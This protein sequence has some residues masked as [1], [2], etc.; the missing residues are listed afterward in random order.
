MLIAAFIRHVVIPL[1][2]YS[3][4]TL[5]ASDYQCALFCSQTLGL[6][7]LESEYCRTAENST[8]KEH[9]NILCKYHECL[10]CSFSSLI[11]F[12]L[13]SIDSTAALDRHLVRKGRERKAN[14]RLSVYFKPDI[15]PASTT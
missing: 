3:T 11:A 9:V 5:L 13:C 2:I 8:A 4:H 14:H 7:I 15:L 12:C 10:L 1:H 6:I